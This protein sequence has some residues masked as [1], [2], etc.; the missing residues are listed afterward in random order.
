MSPLCVGD[1]VQ[2][3][4]S[5]RLSHLQFQRLFRKWQ[6]SLHRNLL[7]SHTQAA[8][9]IGVPDLVAAR[10]SAWTKPPLGTCPTTTWHP[11]T[12][13]LIPPPL[14]ECLRDKEQ[15]YQRRNAIIIITKLTQADPNDAAP[16]V[17]SI[18]HGKSHLL[19]RNRWGGGGRGSSRLRD[20]SMA[21]L[22]FSST[23]RSNED[24]LLGV[25]RG[26]GG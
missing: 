1:V 23:N 5:N 26:R 2:V 19:I 10:I 7:V 6:N 4:P 22:K 16:P 8:V 25:R 3:D 9:M 20:C 15:Y 11:F 17:G 12:H 18:Q 24:C 21:Q 13:T 14:Q